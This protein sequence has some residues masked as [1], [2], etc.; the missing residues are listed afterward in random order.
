MKKFK[1]FL[2]LFVAVL[3]VACSGDSKKTEN[4][5]EQKI[6]KIAISKAKGSDGYLQYQKWVKILA[7][8]AECYD[9]YFTTFDSAMM[10]FDDCA[11]LIISG[12]PDVFPGLYE[13]E[14]DT[15]RC[16]YIDKRRDTLEL[17]LIKKALEMK[18][19]I[20]GVCRGQQIL[21]VALGGSLI[22]DIPADFD[23]TV[24]HRCEKSDTCFHKVT[25]I[26]G[27]LLENICGVNSGIVNTNHHQA[28][29]EISTKLKV[30]S[31][32][33]DG[34]TE[35]VEW[36]SPKDKSFLIAVQWHPERLDTTN[37]LSYKI[38][39]RFI[40]ESKKYLKENE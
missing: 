39:K 1:Q 28:I 21:N 9:M 20:L 26:N 35:S 12:G 5:N 38:G 23:T 13:K 14:K 25:L 37:E 29:D 17:A 24:I 31:K 15:S 18:I 16:G 27:S 7:P 11:G 10:L 40:I 3:I 6:L 33:E 4:Q 32:T 8:K 2:Y 30:S 22:I 36:K 19:P 34:L